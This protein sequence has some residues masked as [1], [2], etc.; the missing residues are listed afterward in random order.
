M[1]Q[2]IGSSHQ[3]EQAN[4]NTDTITHT[5]TDTKTNSDIDPKKE[6]NNPNLARVT[7]NW[8]QP[9]SREG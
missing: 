8:L 4:T 6:P 7:T 9:L 1:L 5:N 3:A 2:Q